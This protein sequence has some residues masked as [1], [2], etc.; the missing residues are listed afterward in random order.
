MPSSSATDGTAHSGVPET[1]SSLGRA[2][3]E[4]LG[5]KDFERLAALLDPEIGGNGLGRGGRGSAASLV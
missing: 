1:D 2:F 3:V 4:A 5:A